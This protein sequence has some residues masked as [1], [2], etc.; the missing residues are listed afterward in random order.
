MKSLPLAFV[1][2]LSP[3]LVFFGYL[4]AED[5]VGVGRGAAERDKEMGIDL[6][7][8]EHSPEV[9][10]VLGLAGVCRV[11]LSLADRSN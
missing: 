7:I 11:P 3:P 4:E 1:N 9:L 10:K 2:R 6:T 8:L 5:T